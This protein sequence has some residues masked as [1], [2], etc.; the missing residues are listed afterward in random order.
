MTDSE[1]GI[2]PNIDS[3]LTGTTLKIYKTLILA[4]RSIGPRELQKMLNLSS[5]SLAIFHL[6]KLARAGLLSKLEDG[7]YEVSRVYLKHFVRLRTVLVPRLIFQA[8]MSLF[9][10]IGWAIIY[11]SPNFRAAINSQVHSIA[12]II[13]LTFLYGLISVGILT[14]FFWF[15]TFRVL[16]QEKI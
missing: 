8:T 3:L 4:G 15:E 2:P 13:Q 12:S 6:E 14:I 5:P 7:S 9:L 10:L 16:R 11:I 1:N